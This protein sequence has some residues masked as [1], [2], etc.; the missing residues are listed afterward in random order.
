VVWATGYRP[1]YSWIDLPI[2][3]ADGHIDHDGGVVRNAPGLYLMGLPMMRTRKSTYIDGVADD[4]RDLSADMARRLD[5][6]MTI[7]AF[8]GHTGRA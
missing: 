1:D 7:T 4:A 2:V 6:A 3:G 8:P 5:R